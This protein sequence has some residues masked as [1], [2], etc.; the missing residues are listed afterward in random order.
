MKKI[1][2]IT[3]LLFSCDDLGVQE[4]EDSFSYY[5][6]LAYGWSKIFEND[7]LGVFT[8]PYKTIAMTGIS[9]DGAL[10]PT[11]SSDKIGMRDLEYKN[12]T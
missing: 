9:K 1:L 11:S 3:L 5:D 4:F 8:R 12:Y 7:I 6:H 2:Y 10:Y